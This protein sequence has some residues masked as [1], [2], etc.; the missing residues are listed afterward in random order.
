MQG[1]V[2]HHRR[3]DLAQLARAKGRDAGVKSFERE[4]LL[5]PILSLDDAIGIKDQEV[6]RFET[7]KLGII[8]GVLLEADN[9]SWLRVDNLRGAVSGTKQGRVMTGGATFGFSG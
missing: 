4:G 1:N 6:T 9:R 7:Y 2:L 5:V 3:D 8:S